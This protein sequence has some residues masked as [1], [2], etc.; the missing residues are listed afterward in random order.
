MFK[1]RL[2]HQGIPLWTFLSLFYSLF[3]NPSH[4]SEFERFLNSDERLFERRDRS[5]FYHKNNYDSMVT[6]IICEI[7]FLLT[8]N[9]IRTMAARAVPESYRVPNTEQDT[10]ATTCIPFCC[11]SI[12]LC[13]RTQWGGLWEYERTS[14]RS[15]LWKWSLA[16]VLK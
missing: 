16:E 9:Y 11:L 5:N 13:T 1:N 4:D 2:L 3:S 12:C 6:R 10:H 7:P 8:L 14:F 15:R